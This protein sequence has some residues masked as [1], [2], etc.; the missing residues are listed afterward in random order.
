MTDATEEL[1][2][3]AYHEAGHA[4]ACVLLRLALRSA[5]IVPDDA[6]DGRVATR[7]AYAALERVADGIYAPGD[8]VRVC[9]GLVATLAGPAAEAR[10]RG[11]DHPTGVLSGSDRDQA[12]EWC[13]RASGPGQEASAML[14]WL[15]CRAD[16]LVASPPHWKAV[17]AVADA[18]LDRETL[19]A[20]TVRRIARAELAG[21]GVAVVT[22]SSLTPKNRGASRA[23]R[24][25]S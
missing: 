8:F 23:P 18:L 24:L 1:R 25:R 2:E 6:S 11:L 5:S 10:Y 13:L 21:P 15:A 14:V 20:A 9:D 7:P 12:T 4:V 16:N 19:S 3:L 22:A 17:A